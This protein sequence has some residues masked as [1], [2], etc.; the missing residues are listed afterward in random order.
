LAHRAPAAGPGQ[1]SGIAQGRYGTQQRK[2][3]ILHLSDQYRTYWET[4]Q[5]QLALETWNAASAELPYLRVSFSKMGSVLITGE[6]DKGPS[7][8][9]RFFN[10]DTFAIVF[11]LRFLIQSMF[12]Q[13]QQN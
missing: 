2:D 7:Y 6:N 9:Q 11:N 5:T 13:G 10:Q 12:Q 1:H 3:V 4:S 8:R